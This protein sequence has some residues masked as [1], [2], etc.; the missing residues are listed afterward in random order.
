MSEQRIK[1]SSIST[2]LNSWRLAVRLARRDARRNKARSLLVVALVA[3]PVFAASGLDI[4]TAA[5]VASRD[6][7]VQARAELGTAAGAVLFV[8]GCEQI[9]Q[10]LLPHAD[11][12][13]TCVGTRD[14]EI[15]EIEAALPD[16]VRL[17]VAP[18]PTY[19]AMESSTTGIG[20]MIELRDL[21]EPVLAGMWNV[22]EGRLPRTLDEIALSPSSANLLGLRIG[23]T[24]K[25]TPYGKGAISTELNVVGIAVNPSKT[26][27]SVAFPKPALL[28]GTTERYLMQSGL[29]V[30]GEVPL[31]YIPRL[32]A[33]GVEV[34]TRTA[35][36]D[37]ASLCPN[38]RCKYGLAPTFAPNSDPVLGMSS[39]SDWIAVFLVSLLVVLQVSLVAGPSFAIQLRKRQR[40]L[41]LLASN[42]APA[43][44]LRRSM[45]ASGLFL[46]ALG[47][48]VGVAASWF[49]VWL[50][51]EN[52][53]TYL[54]SG[55]LGPSVG[56]PPFPLSLIGIG[57][58][59]VVA[60]LAAA[61]IPAVI[62]GRANVLSTL[63]GRVPQRK[64]RTRVPLAGFALVIVGSVGLAALGLSTYPS[65]GVWPA[66]RENW[67]LLGILVTEVGYVMLL[68]AVVVLVGVIA[69]NAPVA[70][71]LAARDAARHRLR[72]AAAASAVAAAA[73]ISLAAGVALENYT[74]VSSQQE[75][76]T[77]SSFSISTYMY[78]SPPQ[79]SGEVVT[80]NQAL[81]KAISAA[82]SAL[83][84][85]FSLGVAA[86]YGKAR[87]NGNGDFI[88]VMCRSPYYRSACPALAARHSLVFSDVMVV[89][90]SA[91]LRA[92]F[93]DIP[94]LEGMIGALKAG[95][96][97]TVDP[98]IID[99][100]DSTIQL[101]VNDQEFKVKADTYRSAIVP[102]GIIIGPE[103]FAKYPLLAES[104]YDAIRYS[105]GQREDLIR[106][107][108]MPL[109]PSVTKIEQ[110]VFKLNLEFVKAGVDANAYWDSQPGVDMRQWIWLG[111]IGMLL[112]S[113]FVGLTVTALSK[114]DSD[115]DLDT[116]A[117]IGA[118][119]ALRRS[120]AASAAA[121]VTVIGAWIGTLAALTIVQVL[122]G[123]ASMYEW[124]SSLLMPWK[125]IA[126]TC[127]GV[128]VV[129]ALVAYATTRSHF[130]ISQR[131]D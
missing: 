76:R 100:A 70:F 25:I 47:A 111:V 125:T 63:Q 78:D 93:G 19:A 106:L 29:V 44:A 120:I 109:D 33:L 112:V 21:N 110:A 119:P 6:P 84:G 85:S 91:A 1:S 9:Q 60:A 14:P 101:V 38:N 123:T 118:A 12:I 51:I 99:P 80:S 48:A 102:A 4:A 89:S 57:S 90:N 2:W 98:H 35:L 79:T 66:G 49:V 95:H 64:F 26:N 72:T 15:T 113:L 130:S 75:D 58:V 16:G 87:P 67:L 37:P 96:A 10:S 117:A 42:G 81:R 53:P 55:L 13:V 39:Q 114:T 23:D 131:R 52:L 17:L 43:G 34:L 86:L 126:A 104:T 127:I 59:G 77:L 65:V 3:L 69:K 94:G 22:T 45:L 40:D 32:N 121:I 50:L 54:I 68:P 27:S 28:G 7:F 116:M 73:A 108:S 92:I 105:D 103:T 8:S 30:D 11:T 31:S 56:M 61:L 82:S 71:R 107:I 62:A 41:G 5:Q 88:R 20:A 122:T 24:V 124:G 46:G 97:I 18:S 74:S 115:R 129:T 83:P 128:P 36:A